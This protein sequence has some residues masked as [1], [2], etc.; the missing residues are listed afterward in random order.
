MFEAEKRHFWF[1]GSRAVVESWLQRAIDDAA[2]G[3]R[4]SLIDVGAGT[5]GMLDR[6]A[7]LC[8]AWGVEYSPDG[9]AF[10]QSRG[11]RVLRGG[12]PHLPLATDR[13]DLALSMDVFEHVEDDVAAM[14][15]VRRV[16]RPG[17]R[18][19]MTV[20]A[21][22]WLWS[23]HD[24]ALHHHRRYDRSMLE[25]RLKQAG[26]RV[27]RCSYFNSLLLPP[28]AAVRL[29]GRIKDR[30]APSSAPPASDV[31]DVVE[32]LNGILSSVFGAERHLL[33]HGRLPLGASLIAECEA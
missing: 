28:I 19:I 32:P 16:L 14:T 24:E 33:A 5:G 10:C 7:P 20:P 27:V 1:R 13:F 30:L 18:L 6:I 25:T 12:L 9:A 29:A 15:D 4:P 31:G 3:Q 21:L 23:R 8:D 11:V 26:F 22:Q 2:M 17:G